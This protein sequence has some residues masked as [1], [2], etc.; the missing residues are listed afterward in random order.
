MRKVATIVLGILT[1][2]VCGSGASAQ[3]E[4]FAMRNAARDTARATDYV[5]ARNRTRTATATASA[6]TF[7]KGRKSDV[8]PAALAEASALLQE[9][10]A[11]RSDTRAA[12]AAA[13][14]MR[15]R[16]AHQASDDLRNRSATKDIKQEDSRKRR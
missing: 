10:Q 14:A 16:V 9:A 5:S 12:R 3:D 1:M 11:R 15:T 4:A 7:M 6:R 13:G 2:S 8:A